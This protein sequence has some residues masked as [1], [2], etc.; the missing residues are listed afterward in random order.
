MIQEENL[1]LKEKMFNIT[2]Y[3]QATL[4]LLYLGVCTLL[5]I[6]FAV[7]KASRKSKNPTFEDWLNML[8][9]FRYLK[10]KQNYG[11]K[12]SKDSKL[13]ILV[14]SAYGRDKEIRK[15]TTEYLV[16]MRSEPTSWYSKLQQ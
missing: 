9:I 1:E 4:C 6:L 12:F 5:D 16:M 14:D 2:K 11:I 15:S 13:K 7:N 8:R 3:E 10:S